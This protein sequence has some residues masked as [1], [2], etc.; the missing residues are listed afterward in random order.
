[1]HDGRR[2]GGK[3]R[4]VSVD[5]TICACDDSQVHWTFDEIN[6]EWFGGAYLHWDSNDVE[7][8]FALAKEIHGRDWV[9][10]REFDLG[11]IAFLGVGRRGG[12]SQF[13]RVYWFGKRMQA[14]AGLPGADSIRERLLAND[15]AADSELT[16]IHLL[17]SRQLQTEAEI[18]PKVTVG[19]RRDGDRKRIMTLRCPRIQSAASCFTY[20]LMAS[21][22]CVTL[23]S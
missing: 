18:G 7:R 14:I 11:A 20:C 5:D 19:D 4:S 12:F 21:C 1:M 23:A 10:G 3:F 6:R 13:L 8:A 17:R 15:P 2:S 9:L 16:A 22:A